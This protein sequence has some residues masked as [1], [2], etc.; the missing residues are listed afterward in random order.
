MRKR[1]LRKRRFVSLLLTVCLLFGLS[2]C[3]QGDAPEVPEKFFGVDI[4]RNDPDYGSAEQVLGRSSGAYIM[5]ARPND[6]LHLYNRTTGVFSDIEWRQEE[7]EQLLNITEGGGALHAAITDEASDMIWVRRYN[8]DSDSW[9]DIAGIEVTDANWCLRAGGFFVDSERHFYLVGKTSKDSGEKTVLTRF[10]FVGEEESQYEIGGS[11]I[12]FSEP[13]SGVVECLAITAEGIARYE[14]SEMEAVEKWVFAYPIQS[15]FVLETSSADLLCVATED[16]LLFLDRES[17]E[18]TAESNLVENGVQLFHMV[19]GYYNAADELVSLYG[20]SSDYRFRFCQL[21]EQA[22]GEVK[23]R[24][25][26]VYGTA[27]LSTV[28][29]ERIAAFNSSNEDYYVT[30]RVY[31]TGEG[32]FTNIGMTQMVADLIGGNGPDIIGMSGLGVDISYQELVTGGYLTDLTGYLEGLTYAD[33]LFWNVIDA[34]EVNGEIGMLTPHFAMNGIAVAPKYAVDL[35]ELDTEAFLELIERNQ[36]EKSL[37]GWDSADISLSVMLRARQWEFLDPVNNEAHFDSPA[38]IEMLKLCKEYGAG[39]PFPQDISPTERNKEILFNECYLSDI[40]SYLS[41]ILSYGR[42]YS[43]YGYPTTEGDVYLASPGLDACAISAGSGHKD[44]AWEFLETLLDAGYQKN[45]NGGF[46]YGIA[47]RESC[48]DAQG[49]ETKGWRY[50]LDDSYE[51]YSFTDEQGNTVWGLRLAG[52]EIPYYITD[53]EIAIVKDMVSNGTFEIS[54]Y[55]SQ[56]GEILRE[57][58]APYFAGDKSAE[59]VADIIQ[60]RVTIFLKE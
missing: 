36:G 6:V 51:Y 23:N 30:I 40:G 31:D 1:I 49:E 46:A 29:Q 14:L 5:T 16:K 11:V 41:Y 54:S 35:K 38:F 8:S 19:G 37:F 20:E 9:V 57:E 39:E 43:L 33:D 52:E 53:D 47:I 17:G 26:L 56:I 45:F 58:S 7:G 18:L 48:F 55:L 42:E 21:K 50:T 2:A 3:R 32:D 4:T 25:E 44:G 60:S 34:C 22:E 12:G 28:M 10:S 13:E 27:D 59:E 15:A 24:T